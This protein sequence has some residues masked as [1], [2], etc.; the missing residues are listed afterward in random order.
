MVGFSE[1][2]LTLIS[3]NTLLMG[4]CGVPMRLTSNENLEYSIER[5]V[6]HYS[7]LFVLPSYPQ[8]I[9]ITFSLC[10]IGSVLA[11][12]WL[13]GAPIILALEFGLLLFSLSAFSDLIVRQA[14]TKSDPLYN[15][16]RCAAV[17]MFSISL[18]FAF[19]LVGSS[20]TRF[21]S[22][23]FWNDSFAIGFAA[24]CILRLVVF[25]STSFVSNWRTVG[26][27][28]TQPLFSLLPMVYVS[29]SV[30]YA[31]NYTMALCLMASIPITILTAFAFVASINKVGMETLQTPTTTVLKA[32]LA[33]WMENL[34]DPVESLFEKF[35]REK[36][37]DFS[38]LAFKSERSVEAVTVVSSFHPGPFKNVG[39]SVLPFMIQEAL[40]KKLKCV[41]SVPHGLFGHEF[42]LSSQRQNQKVLKGMLDAANFANFANFEPKATTFT[43]TKKGAASASCQIFG[44]CALL[45]LTLAPE[46]TEDFPQEI[47]DAILRETSN[48]GLAHVMIINAHNSINRYFDVGGTVESLKEVALEALRRTSKEEPSPLEVG[49]AR[50]SPELSPKDGMGPGGICALVL[51]VDGQTSAYITIDGNNMISGLREKILEALRE[52]GIDAGEVLTT[53]THAVNAVAMTARGYHPLGEAIPHEKL[54]TYTRD[55]V[56][57]ALSS[58]KSASA[59]WRTG[60]VPKVG[61]IGEKQIQEMSLLA[62]RA[63]KRAKKTAV[64]LFAAAGLLL[65]ALLYIL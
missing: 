19:L 3:E 35:G 29:Y 58:M 54:I 21:Y 30:G 25:S 52:T 20:L 27:S 15:V 44:N 61:V 32:F 51:R 31:L 50:V 4:L 24:V 8:I 12:F 18:W 65:L 14:F 17:S 63:L 34:A 56:K 2:L 33:N 23:V 40:G 46:T 55:A 43:R 39:S 62:D 37:I 38:L 60:T 45:T 49:A 1:S 26:A 48:L 41:V 64:P 59:A 36:T 28:L 13:A 11:V 22:W 6:K 57:A 5:A 53:D 9:L 47:G 42:D 10:L 7:S 16:R